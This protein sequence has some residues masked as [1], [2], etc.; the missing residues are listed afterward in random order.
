MK[1]RMKLLYAPPILL[2]LILLAGCG[3]RKYTPNPNEEIYGTWTNGKMSAQKMVNTADG[4]KQ[5][6]KIEDTQPYSEWKGTIAS[7]WTDKEGNI[8]YRFFGTITAG[9]YAGFTYTELDKLNRSAT[10]WESIWTSPTNAQE[11]AALTYPTRMDPTSA[12][13]SIYNRAER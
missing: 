11:A 10:V 4:W 12:E 2:S 8:W 1:T 7:K 6:L 5:Y 13:Y 9:P 3:P